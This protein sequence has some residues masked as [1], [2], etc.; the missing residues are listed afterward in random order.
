VTALAQRLRAG[1]PLLA[2]FVK[3][4]DPAVVE[5]VAAAGFDV[6]IADVEHAPLEA[7][8]LHVIAAISA[9][10]GVA[11]LAR[12]GE[13][14]DVTRILESGVDGIQ[15]GDVSDVA[16]L[17][18]AVRFRPDGTRGAAT[19]HRAAGFG[20]VAVREWVA[21]EVAVVAQVESA[22]GIAALPAMLADAPGPDAWF[23]GPVDLSCDLGHPGELD[24]PD[25]RGAIDA[26]VEAIG[27]AGRTLGIFAADER[28]AAAWR[29]RGA[30][31]V[32]VGSDVTLLSQRAGAV[33]GAWKETR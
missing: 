9:L 12:I 7:R 15:V 26:A 4:A 28:A 27:S 20:R 29:A 1:E 32:A 17:R 10:H 30:T 18:R 22:A 11:T 3:S 8:D 31:Y 25:V 2:T 21:R 24:H 33:A 5:A 13:L 16:A 14:G 19:S 23:V 6:L